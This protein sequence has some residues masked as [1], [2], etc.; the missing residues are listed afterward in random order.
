MHHGIGI[1]KRQL[2]AQDSYQSRESLAVLFAAL[3]ELGDEERGVSAITGNDKG[4]SSSE[5]YPRSQSQK[6]DERSENPLKN[7]TLEKK[8]H[9]VSAL[10]R[11]RSSSYS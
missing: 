3:I 5:T 1:K 7:T 11:R 9:R 8:S 6:V 2:C 10:R 4:Q